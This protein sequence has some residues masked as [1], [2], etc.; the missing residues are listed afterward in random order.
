MKKKNVILITV[1]VVPVALFWGM[2]GWFLLGCRVKQTDDIS[3]YQALSGEKPGKVALRI[4]GFDEVQCPYDLPQLGDLEPYEQVRFHHM[5]KRV[6]IFCSHAYTLVVSF[7]QAHYAAQKADLVGK[8]TF[9]PPESD[10]IMSGY[11]YK[12]DGFEIRAVEGGEYPHE[13]LFIG[14]NDDRREIAVVYYYDLDLDEVTQPL[15]K[16]LTEETGWEQV[17]P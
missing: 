11:A 14:C 9:C 3:Y 1:I 7:D 5:A 13:M 2:V 10:E 4:S 6:S 17:I 12:M 16:F 8:Y 15:G